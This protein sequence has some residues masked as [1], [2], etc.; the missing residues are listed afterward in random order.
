M[1]K[2]NTQREI[3]WPKAA[4]VLARRLN[5]IKSN[6]EEVGILINDTKDPVKRTVILEICKVSLEPLESFKKQKSCPTDPELSKD[7]PKD[8][9]DDYTVFFRNSSENHIQ[10]LELKDTKDI[11]QP[12]YGNQ[13]IGEG[14]RTRTSTCLC[15]RVCYLTLDFLEKHTVDRHPGLTAYPGP[16]DIQKFERE[17]RE[18]QQ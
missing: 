9:S 16:A 15:C 6:L 5:E 8:T 14:S 4:D 7:T 2:I 10:N 17:Q 13:N 1:L 3:L 12:Y 11:L 18:K